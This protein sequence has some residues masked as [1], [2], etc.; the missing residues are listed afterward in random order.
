MIDDLDRPLG[1][2]R[3]PP[4]KRGG[5]GRSVLIAVAVLALGGVLSAAYFGRNGVDG[6]SGGG[7]PQV[8][9]P[10]QPLARRAAPAVVAGQPPNEQA[11]TS[12][13]A[14]QVVVENGV[15][16]VRG[17]AVANAP[18]IIQVP[19]AAASALAPAP[20]WRVTEK[21]RYGLL[22]RRGKDGAKPADIYARPLSMQAPIQPGTPRVAIVV[23]GMGIDPE[24]TE[25]A[26]HKLPPEVSLAFAPYG[27]RAKQLAAE[28][29]AAGHEILLQSPMEPFDMRNAPGPHVLRVGDS[30]RELDDLRWQMGRMVGYIGLVN[31]LGGRFTADQSATSSL[32]GELA[33]RGLDFVDDGSSPQSLTGQIAQQKDVGFVKA[34]LRLDLSTQPQ[35][36]D[37]AL[38]RLERLAEDRGIAVGF[39]AGLPGVVNRIAG[40]AA[41]LKLDGV[42][43][44]PVSAAIRAENEVKNVKR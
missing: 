31:F 26:I 30:A 22:P 37:T 1:V 10:I 38:S 15:K 28:A 39:A 32:M 36:I 5:H 19:Q 3:Q 8:I 34:D 29:R 35:Q 6:G 18:A 13:P 4:P 43:L 17:G 40:F 11:K 33:R 12:P 21:S 7:E 23:G 9:A 44:V 16:V 20:D 25:R 27:S 14:Q 42:A 2:D 24:A 41:H